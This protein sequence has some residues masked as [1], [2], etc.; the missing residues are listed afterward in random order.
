[1]VGL[2]NKMV[3]FLQIVYNKSLNYEIFDKIMT[4]PIE[5]GLS[6]VMWS[7]RQNQWKLAF[8]GLAAPI[9]SWQKRK[10]P[11]HSTPGRRL[12]S[13]KMAW[14]CFLPLPVGDQKP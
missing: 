14:K 8:R 1:M 2:L 12:M 10:R 11:T 4:P 9:C 13:V 7:P 5:G 3:A 6:E